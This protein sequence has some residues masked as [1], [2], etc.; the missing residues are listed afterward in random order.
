MSGLV[1]FSG[2]SKKIVAAIITVATLTVSGAAVFLGSFSVSGQASVGYVS[3]TGMTTS[4]LSPSISVITPAGYN[5]I[6]ATLQ[7]N[8]STGTSRALDITQKA[9][10]NGIRV[11]QTGSTGRTDSSSGALVAITTGVGNSFG[12]NVYTQNNNPGTLGQFNAAPQFSTTGTDVAQWLG[13][14]TTQITTNYN[15]NYPSSGTILVQNGTSIGESNDS[16][17]VT[18]ASTTSVSGG[19][20]SFNGVAGTLVNRTAG[21]SAIAGAQ[22]AYINTTTTSQLVRSV[23][24]STNGGQPNFYI[25]A[26]NPD[27][28]WVARGGYDN[29]KG[30]GKH[31]IDVPSGY[32]T[33]APTSTDVLRINGRDDLDT[34]YQTGVIFAREGITGRGLVAIGGQNLTNPMNFNA[35]LTVLNSNN[36]GD[37]NNGSLV[38]AQILGSATNTQT[39]D[40]MD[41]GQGGNPPTV[42]AFIDATGNFKNLGSVTTSQ[43]YVSNLSVLSKVIASASSSFQ[44]LSMTQATA[45]DVTSTRWLGWAAASGSSAV[46]G[47]YGGIA[48]STMVSGTSIFLGS[49]GGGGLLSTATSGWA[50]TDSGS[51]G[52]MT[53]P[54]GTL[55]W[56]AS[57]T[58]MYAAVIQ[59]LD[60][61]SARANG[62][63]V[64]IRNSSNITTDRIVNFSSNGTARFLI[65]PAGVVGINTTAPTGANGATSMK[66]EVVGVA[67]TTAMTISVPATNA[68]TD[69]LMCISATGTVQSEAASCTVSSARFKENIN[70]LSA[71]KLRDEVMKLRAVTFDWKEGYAPGSGVNGGGKESSGFIAEE[72]ALIDPQLVV[73]EPG[74]EADVAWENEHYPGV[75]LHKNGMDLVPK[76]IDYPRITYVLAGAIQAEDARI[77]ALENRMSLWD[78]LW[79]GLKALFAAL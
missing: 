70:S 40:L 66:L 75:V 35:R 17:F 38:V 60:G 24:W 51:A 61:S 49:A 69:N 79:A 53:S 67:S 19:P 57:G 44:A 41:W 32:G 52:Q 1:D 39:A 54:T 43:E 4:T 56:V 71:Q 47:I 26:P 64:D 25:I 23:D 68:L 13:T 46:I 3:S 30:Q 7:Q 42:Q 36:Y 48:S 31:E 76:T 29:S 65:T 37:T 78:K 9:A 33:A 22:I 2:Y 59:Q 50:F 12:L 34:T 16:V 63:A 15:G 74:S 27:E 58:N 6:T 8:N 11:T 55:Y 45:T 14:T 18:Y 10:G 62:L 5:G 28:E 73:Y 20:Y 21:M 77:T 72:V